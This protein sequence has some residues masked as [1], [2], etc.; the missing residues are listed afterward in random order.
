MYLDPDAHGAIIGFPVSIGA[1]PGAP[2]RAFN[3]QLSGQILAVVRPQL[4]VQCWRSVKFHVTDPD[5]TL[6]L[7]FTPDRADTDRG[8]IDLIHLDVPDHDYDDVNKGWHKHYWE[9]W[10]NHLERKQRM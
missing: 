7:M 4:I 8:R 5:S 1:D 10:R 3:D 9:P 2:F 6:I